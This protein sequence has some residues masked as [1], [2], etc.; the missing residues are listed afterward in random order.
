VEPAHDGNS[1]SFD[2][3]D[4]RIDGSDDN[5]VVIMNPRNS[6]PPASQQ[7]PHIQYLQ[8]M[9]NTV[10]DSTTILKR[11]AD[12]YDRNDWYM[13]DLNRQLVAI[14]D[15]ETT[16]HND[17]RVHTD[18][19]FAAIESKMD[20]LLQKME[21]TWT[22]NMALREAYHA[23]REEIALLKAAMD[24]L[25]KK[26]HNNITISAPPSPGTATS[27][28]AM[29]EMTMQL[30][31]IQNDIQDVLDAVGNPPGK[32]KQRTSSQDNKLTIPMNR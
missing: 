19:R 8:T 27:S 22:E 28:A 16:A 17:D 31:H 1:L 9:A 14:S 5:T 13:H 29:E 11:L 10:R 2:G 23:S 26:L 18:D 12:C 25:T 30:S 24:T 6:G 4:E 7:L 32:R 3:G 15:R 21:T 20:S